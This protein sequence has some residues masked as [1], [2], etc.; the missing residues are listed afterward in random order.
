MTTAKTLIAACAVAWVLSAGVAAAQSCGAVPAPPPE[1]ERPVNPGEPPAKPACIDA[2]GNTSRCRHGEIERANAEVD[3]FNE[4]IQKFNID[5]QTY[6][7]HLNRYTTD[8]GTYAHCELD[9]MNGKT[10]H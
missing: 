8:V 3:A 4:R 7:D 1:S 10:P 2:R 6:L 9:I 5:S